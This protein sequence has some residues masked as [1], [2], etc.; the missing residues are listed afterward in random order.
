M[1]VTSWPAASSIG[2]NRRPIA[3]LAPARKIFTVMAS[4]R[5]LQPL[6]RLG[7]LGLAHLRLLALFFFFLDDL[8]RRARDKIGVAELGIDTGDVG[9]GLRHLLGEPRTFGV[10][11]DQPRKLQTHR[12][13]SDNKWDDAWP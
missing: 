8:F 13:A 3:P 10:E 5:A 1:P 11:I 2:V 7:D 9:I 4:R 12:L 6:Q